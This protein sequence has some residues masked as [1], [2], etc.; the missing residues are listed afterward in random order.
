M[1]GRLRCYQ[2]S[3][4][5]THHP[6]HKGV[7]N[8]ETPG[9]QN[10]LPVSEEAPNQNNTTPES[11]VRTKPTDCTVQKEMGN[12]E[13]STGTII[14]CSVVGSGIVLFLIVG[15]TLLRKKSS[16]SLKNPTK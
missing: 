5:V 6:R 14:A 9:V 11:D 2:A 8:E 7:C 15:I 10:R 3:I 12:N 16:S 1:N 4:S 13:S